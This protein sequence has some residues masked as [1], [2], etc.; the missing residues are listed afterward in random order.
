MLRVVEQ[1]LFLQGF[2]VVI[3][4]GTD[5]CFDGN[6]EDQR[7]NVTVF[8]KSHAS[9]PAECILHCV[10]KS[11][12]RSVNFRKRNCD[13]SYGNCELIHVQGTEN[14]QNLVK[15]EEF[16]HYILIQPQKTFNCGCMSCK[17]DIEECSVVGKRC[18][19]LYGQDGMTCGEIRTSCADWLNK[20]AGATL[21]DGVYFINPEGEGKAHVRVWCDMSTDGGGW[22]VFQKRKDG[23]ENFNRTWDS[24]KYGFGSRESD[25]WL[26]LHRINRMVKNEEQVLRVDLEDWENNRAYA[27]YKEFSIGN[28]SNEYTLTIGGYEG[29][30]GDSLEYQNGHKFSTYDSDNDVDSNRNCA[31]VFA[32]GWWFNQ[33][34]S[35]NL[36]GHYIAGGQHLE[37]ASTGVFWEHFRG[38]QYS[39]KYSEMKIRPKS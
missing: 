12:C 15:D 29:N 26:G 31:K 21:E 6:Y 18:N 35:S 7:L 30:A 4:F 37:A 10:N 27:L 19:C 20:S 25:F 2:I 5:F 28:Q 1:C 8:G 32:G 17:Q 14:P 16:D 34:V 24:Y 3:A 36:N 22:T 38:V 13:D 39:L 9:S 23:L 11:C 33:C